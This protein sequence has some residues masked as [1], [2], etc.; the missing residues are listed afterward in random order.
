VFTACAAFV[1]ITA[2]ALVTSND[3]GLSVPDWPTS[4][5]YLV[6]VPSLRGR[7]ALRMESPHGGRHSGDADPG[8][9]HVDIV[10]GAAALDALAGG[11]RLLQPSSCRRF[12]ADL[13]SCY[14][15]R[16]RF[17]RRTQPWLKTFFCIAVAIALFTGRK[18]VEE[19]PRVEFDSRRPSLVTLTLLSIFVL[20]VQLVL[21]GCFVITE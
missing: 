10:G 15:S 7:R 16:P 17:P 14:S 1:V 3:A 11:W 19:Q 2:G 21:G 5:G 8:N 18:W 13:Q 9:R 4:F 12:S 20:Y 6:K